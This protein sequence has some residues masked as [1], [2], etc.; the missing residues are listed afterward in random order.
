MRTMLR[1]WPA[2]LVVALAACAQT[3][4]G[5]LGSPS[6]TSVAGPA[7]GSRAIGQG[8]TSGVTDLATR[9]NLPTSLDPKTGN[10]KVPTLPSWD[11]STAEIV[12]NKKTGEGNLHLVQFLMSD[13]W[14]FWSKMD[15][16][17]GT[18]TWTFIRPKQPMNPADRFRNPDGTP[19][20]SGT[21]VPGSRP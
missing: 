16:E 20:T 11:I 13:S 2:A 12:I 5:G 9:Q 15:N 21:V 19:R 14:M 6:G 4:G 7:D 10:R 18:V 8:S 1:L 17:D 3:S